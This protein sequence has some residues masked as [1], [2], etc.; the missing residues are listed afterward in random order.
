M[1]ILNYYLPGKPQRI[2]EFTVP[3]AS[4]S[5]GPPPDSALST[6]TAQPSIKVVPPG[7]K[8]VNVTKGFEV[9]SMKQDGGNCNQ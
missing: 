6:E 7:A 8:T 3:G 1:Y 5:A 2:D 4:A 9:L